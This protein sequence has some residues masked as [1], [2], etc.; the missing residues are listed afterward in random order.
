MGSEGG[1]EV[2]DARCVDGVGMCV[3]E[4]EITEVGVRAA[5]TTA[6]PDVRYAGVGV[7]AVAIK[8]ERLLG[9]SQAQGANREAAGV[10][11]ADE[12]VLVAVIGRLAGKGN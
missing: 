3:V 6:I 9:G 4:V 1:N 7:D 2:D 8:P 10:E 12:S 11:N 5:V